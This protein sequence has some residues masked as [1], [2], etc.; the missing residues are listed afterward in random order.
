LGPFVCFWLFEDNTAEGIVKSKTKYIP[1]NQSAC[2][3]VEKILNEKQNKAVEIKKIYKFA[4]L[5]EVIYNNLYSSYENSICY[6]VTNDYTSKCVMV[7]NDIGW[8]ND[9]NKIVG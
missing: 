2:V 1:Y 4:F 7:E 6:I 5:F 3:A 9:Q 8:R